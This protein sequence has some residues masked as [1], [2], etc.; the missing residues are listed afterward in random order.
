MRPPYSVFWNRI[1]ALSICLCALFAFSATLS[2]NTTTF[3]LGTTNPAEYYLPLG[4]PTVNGHVPIAAPVG[5]YAGI[6]TNNGVVDPDHL[7]F[8]LTGGATT[9][10]NQT[11]N[12]TEAPP[13]GQ[14]QEEAAYLASYMLTLAGQDKIGVT[15]NGTSVTLTQLGSMQIGNFV[16]TVLGPIQ[17]AIWQIMGSLPSQAPYY[18][19]Q[20]DTNSLTTNFVSLAV[21]EWNNVLSHASDPFTIAFNAN[22]M[23]FTPCASNPGQSFVEVHTLPSVPEPGTMVLFGT[24]TLLMGLGCARR[25]FSRRPR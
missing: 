1:I 22:V 9:Y 3:V 20:A 18:I 25:R 5:P 17:M 19:T 8:C 21:T 7:F 13:S 2:A 14:Q 4:E 16:S 24:G 10:S 15:S 6:L 11:Y 23:V 12:G